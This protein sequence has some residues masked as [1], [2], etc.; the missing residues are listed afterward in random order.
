L[1]GVGQWVKRASLDH[2]ADQGLVES[3]A[4]KALVATRVTPAELDSW[5]L[6]ACKDHKV[7]SVR[8]ALLGSLV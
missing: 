7:Q 8:T 3:A 6:T 5:A 2:R 1:E 4:L